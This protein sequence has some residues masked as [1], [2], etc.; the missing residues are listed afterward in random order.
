MNP[1]LA[2]IFAAILLALGIL[3]LWQYRGGELRRAKAQANASVAQA[4]F[5]AETTRIVERTTNKE[6]T[7]VRQAE[8][9]A[10]AVQSAAGAGI[11]IPLDVLAAWSSGIDSMRAPAASAADDRRP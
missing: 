5:S 6:R 10:D 3:A 4:Q 1:R 11:P 2:A 9:H 7:V 8:V